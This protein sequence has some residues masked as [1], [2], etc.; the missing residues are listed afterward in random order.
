MLS[1][2]DRIRYELG[3]RSKYPDGKYPGE[4][5]YHGTSIEAARKIKTEGLKLSKT[6]HN[7]PGVWVAH[8]ESDALSYAV[9]QGRGIGSKHV[10]PDD[11][12]LIALV[13]VRP[14]AASLF[15]RYPGQ[16]ASVS[17]KDVPAKH[18]EEVRVYRA[19]DVRRWQDRGE[20]SKLKYTNLSDESGYTYVSILLSKDEEVVSLGDR[21]KYPGGL[22]PN[23]QDE[24]ESNGVDF[25]SLKRVGEAQGSNPGG[26]YEDAAGDK[27]YVKDYKNPDQGAAEHVS[28]A[29]YRAVGID[30][31]VSVLGEGPDHGK[32]ASQI[33]EGKILARAGLT[34]ETANK[35]LDG[36]AADVL[37][38]NWD[39]VGTGHDN[40]LVEAGTGTPVRIDQG[41]TLT[42][43]AQGAPKPADLLKGIGEW[44]SL[45][46]QNSYYRAVFT[47]AGLK[48]P[49]DP[50]FASRVKA[51][52]SKIVKARPA[53]GWSK[54]VNRF[55]PSTKDAV[56][57]TWAEMLD[58][59]TEA[60]ARKVGIDLSMSYRDKLVFLLGDRS[61]YPDGKY[62]N[63]QQSGPKPPAKRYA[64]KQRPDGKWQI[65][66]R[67]F[68]YK[69]KDSP[70]GP[71]HVKATKEEALAKAAHMEAK[72]GA[73]HPEWE[74]IAEQIAVF[75]QSGLHGS[76][77][78]KAN[79]WKAKILAKEMKATSPSDAAS[80]GMTPDQFMAATSNIAKAESSLKEALL[81]PA[82]D[83]WPIGDD[84]MRIDGQ[85]YPAVVN[86]AYEKWMSGLNNDELEAVERYTANGYDSWNAYLRMTQPKMGTIVNPET[87]PTKTNTLQRALHRA[88]SPPP[89]ELVWR[90]TGGASF[91]DGLSSGDT[92]K[93]TGFTSASISVGTWS[94]STVLEI[95]PVAG[96]YVD[97]ISSS[98]GEKEYLLPHAAR[99]KV[100]GRKELKLG[101]SKKTVVQLKM[102]DKGPDVVVPEKTVKLSY[103]ERLVFMLGDRSKYPGGK[104]PNEEGASESPVGDEE[105]DLEG[106]GVMNMPDISD[107]S[108]PTMIGAVDPVNPK[109]KSRKKRVPYQGVMLGRRPTEF[110][111]EVLS[112][113]A[114]PKRFDSEVER[115]SAQVV[116]L[117]LQYARDQNLPSLDQG[118]SVVL[119]SAQ[120]RI[121]RYGAAELRNECRRQYLPISLCDESDARFD[122]L[123]TAVASSAIET[124]KMLSTEW[125]SEVTRVGSRT[126]RAR[127]PD[128]LLELATPRADWGVKS[129]VRRL[130]N[131]SF[132]LARRTHMMSIASSCERSNVISLK[133]V[134]ADKAEELVDY[135]IQS[136]VMDTS[137]CDPCADADGLTFE[138]DSDEM[139][140]HQPPYFRC[141]GGDHCRCVQVYVLK[142]GGS[143]VMRGAP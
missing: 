109:K 57:K 12:D 54:V 20:K 29:I 28:N 34:E 24:I 65:Y 16:G 53:G 112:L 84:V 114:I 86:K 101:Y 35:V 66:D 6:P 3:D 138:Y 93:L 136:A 142:D 15:T 10:V 74:K 90:K 59:R 100:V 119:S 88:P 60:L 111:S 39:A 17:M 67:V 130:L 122:G 96:A 79:I 139:I 61:K 36:F 69:D 14:S 31:P 108:F 49:D 71:G 129:A 48:G 64:V 87:L 70:Q 51:Q 72:F 80:V 95:L 45:H 99:Y 37:T 76:E 143:W 38:M 11:D 125:A 105:W 22:Y 77:W 13:V 32:Y 97:P 23:E 134:D 92:I 19:G 50:K 18:I 137:T 94:G 62:P 140:E 91:Y 82:P 107:V 27:W 117:R 33:R 42:F 40:V 5:G 55:A 106:S 81:S 123:S 121:A 25:S 7:M 135:V 4:A 75:N 83:G 41:G 133:V 58:A 110:E 118:L 44:E 52:V 115:A 141:L 132:A 85:K 73:G 120:D 63:E 21:S 8:K 103:R 47:R 43:R 30:V 26:F 126:R 127:R 98:K 1:Y 56:K 113:S 89:P 116:E 124:A 68:T 46:S 104:Y 2:R 131:E 102:L 128:A 78:K 9:G